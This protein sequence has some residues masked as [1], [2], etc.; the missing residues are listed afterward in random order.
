MVSWAACNS[1]KAGHCGG[2]VLDDVEHEFFS[3]AMDVEPF[4][5]FRCSHDFVE[6]DNFGPNCWWV[7][8][9]DC[10]DC[11]HEAIEIADG[12]VDVFDAC[13]FSEVVEVSCLGDGA[14]AGLFDLLLLC[15]SHGSLHAGFIFGCPCSGGCE[16][17]ECKMGFDSFGLEDGVL[18]GPCGR[19]NGG[20]EWLVE[21]LSL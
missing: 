1:D 12:C 20:C 6:F 4:S 10:D 8:F 14:C 11:I 13:H 19:P 7:F 18:V 2:K 17:V 3:V 5:S 16:M 21:Q 9:V 15:D